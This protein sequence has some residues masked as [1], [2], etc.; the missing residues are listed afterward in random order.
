MVSTVVDVSGRL[1]GREVDRCVQRSLQALHLRDLD[2]RRTAL[3][4]LV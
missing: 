2:L 4:E 1:V 3:Q